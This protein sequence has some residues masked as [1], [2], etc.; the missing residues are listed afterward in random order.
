MRVAAGGAR[1]AKFKM[2]N[3]YPGNMCFMDAANIG[4]DYFILQS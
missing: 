2:R 3:K 1:A 4:C